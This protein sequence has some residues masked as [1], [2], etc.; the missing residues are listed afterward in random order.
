MY[1]WRKENYFNNNKINNDIVKYIINKNNNYDNVGIKIKMKNSCSIDKGNN[2][3]K[4]IR[5]LN[6]IYRCEDG[7]ISNNK[8]SDKIRI[9]VV[10]KSR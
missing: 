7:A 1:K 4:S 6:I 3:S 8:N 2:Y 9:D 10:V 5:L